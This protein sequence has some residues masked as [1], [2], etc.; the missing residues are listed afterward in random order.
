MSIQLQHNLQAMN[1]DR[2]YQ[3]SVDRKS[4]AA[5]HLA[6]GYRILG[7]S[8]DAAGLTISEKM[9]YQIRG[10]NQ[11][12]ENVQDGISL[13]QVAEEMVNFSTASILAQHGESMLS[14][15]NSQTSSVLSLLQ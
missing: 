13:I 15:A 4:E 10:L 9:R 2:V 11:A 1:T 14:Q 7:S 12:G 6:S 5:E 8:D 3:L